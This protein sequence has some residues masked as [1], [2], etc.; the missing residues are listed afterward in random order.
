MIKKT[1]VYAVCQ[2]TRKGLIL[3]IRS[4]DLNPESAKYDLIAA[5]EEFAKEIQDTGW[6]IWVVKAGLVSFKTV[7]IDRE[8]AKLYAET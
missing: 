3:G 2:I 7:D 1:Q 4:L 5:E 6:P 8:I